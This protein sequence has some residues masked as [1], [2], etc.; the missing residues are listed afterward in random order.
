MKNA[1]LQLSSALQPTPRTCGLQVS[2][3]ALLALC[4]LFALTFPARTLASAFTAVDVP[5]AG[6]GAQQGTAISAIDAA[7]DITGVYTDS[8]NVEH[9]FVLPAGGTIATFSVAGAGTGA[10]QGTMPASINS[11]GTIAGTYTDSTN[12]SHGFVRAANGTITTFDAPGAPTATKD[13]GTSALS[14][15]DS[16]VIVGFYSTGTY[17]TNSVYY[18]FQ[19]SAGGTITNIVAPNAGPGDGPGFKQG[20]IAYGINA[21]GEIVGGYTDSNF[22]HHGFLLS[23]SAYTVIDPP[24]VG[25]GTCINSHG[26]NFGGTTAGSIDAAGDVGGHYLDTNCVQHGFVRSAS[27]AIAS[28]DAPGA[29]TSPC[30]AIAG[31]NDGICGTAFLGLAT[32]PVGDFTGGY[33]GSDGAIHGLVRPAETG[34]VTAFS[35]PSAATTGTLAGTLGIAIASTASGIAIAGTY[36]DSNSALH[37]FI[38][39]PTLAATTT[40][41]TP[42][43]TPNPSVF[44]EPVTLTAAVSSAAGAPPNGDN[45]T[46]MSGTTSL[47]TATL[48][49]GTAS[50]TTTALPTGT[51]AIVAVYAGDGN[52]AGSASAAIGQTVGKAASFTALTSSPNP[53]NFGQ[54][55]V[56]TATV[57]G[58]FGGTATGSVTFSNGSTSLGAAP[59]SAG[60]ASLTTAALPTG[61]DSITAVYSGDANFAGSASNTA[62][63]TVN[64]QPSGVGNWVWMGGS[65][66]VTCNGDGCFQPGVYGTL[67]KPA[68]GNVPGGRQGAVTWTDKN[69]NLW[70]FGG[71]GSDSTSTVGSLNDLWEYIPS[72]GEWAWMSGSST[73][74]SNNGQSGVYGTLGT[75]AAANVPGGRDA[76]VSWTDSIGNL[77]LFGGQGF[78]AAGRNVFLNDMWEFNISTLEWTWMGGSGTMTCALPSPD[79][80]G[81]P[82]VYGTRG[83]AA[84]GN[85]PGGRYSATASTDSSGNFWLFGGYGYGAGGACCYLNDFWKFNPSTNQWTWVGGGS[86]G[87]QPGVYGTLGTPA[88]GN[89]PGSRYFASSW[90]DSGGRFW[91]NGGYGF[92][93]SGTGGYLDDLWTFNPST[94][95]WTWIDGSSAAT[96][97]SSEACPATGVYGA[98]GVPAAGNIPGDRSGA[99][100]WTDRS[101]NLW[102]F[103]SLVW[104]TN[105]GSSPTNNYLND[106]WEFSTSTKEWAWMDGS[107]SP[108]Q[109]G[110]Y[111]ALG[112]SAAGNTPGGRNF[113]GSWTDS[114]GNLWLFG[115]QGYSATGT[116]GWLN[117]LWVYSPYAIAATPTFNPPAGTYA[118]A[119]SV[120]ISDSIVGAT[121]YYTTDGTAPTTASSVYSGA[122]PVS[123]SETI[124]AMAT[125]SGYSSSAVAAAAYTISLPSPIAPYIAVNGVWNATPESAVTVAAGTSVSLGPWPVSGGAWSWTGPNGFTSTARE[126]DNI[127]LSVGANVYTATYTV[128]GASYTQAFTVTVNP[129]VPYIAVNGVWNATP[130]SAVTVA[131]G[132]SVS[133]GPWPVSGGTWSW[134]GPNGF[135]STAREID[136][137]ALSAGANVYT[138]TYTVNGATYTQAFTIAVGG[139]GA[140]NPIVPYIAV[141]GVWNATSESAVTVASGTS[142]SL[143]PWPASGGSWSW[144][145]PNKFTSAAREIDGIALSEGS[146]VYT[147]TYTDPNACSY[148]QAFTVTVN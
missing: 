41:L 5:G 53:S 40:A 147:A 8:S 128:G 59:L 142:V 114:L 55:T 136:N 116:E 26:R 6:T 13:R 74:G 10:G 72:T 143:G 27:G 104:H 82:G 65:S 44:G 103:G 46:F 138:A 73:V 91:L 57:S 109:P 97:W 111:G 107:S 140:A 96:C 38:Y 58:Q 80:C 87:E 67:G 129:I 117:D 89:V 12:A 110:V 7:G 94:S 105:A 77:W 75:P 69:G 133:L 130:E 121:I 145:G 131:A 99:S 122:I 125:A 100:S 3:S 4:L 64:A 118:S 70:L 88:S 43:P 135:T 62:I 85:I 23:G 132:T 108:N 79:Y 11:S 31:A 16:G 93:A 68:G 35:D 81:Q 148:T 124:R 61:T 141:N 33:V 39:A 18:G 36:S 60:T 137:I 47:G 2:A 51:D 24:G 123:S 19:R 106:L 28:I 113:A 92:D 86:G 83:T 115:G 42:V 112:T 63:Q 119:Q 21:S 17:L 90:I 98:I 144:T 66:T 101:G 134:T 37:G 32:D 49:S 22:E 127:A 84:A 14:I 54:S 45:V 95:L 25:L 29:A 71:L 139:C 52:F 78:D 76:A 34:I 146:N 50:L 126:I 120:T 20:T 102:L 48:T 15:N 9:G 1:T 30:S 56:L